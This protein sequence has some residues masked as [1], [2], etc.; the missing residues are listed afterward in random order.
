MGLLGSRRRSALAPLFGNRGL[1]AIVLAGGLSS[2]GDWLYMTALPVLLFL[3]SGDLGLLGLVAAIRL[4]PFLLLSMPAGALADRVPPAR[5]LVVSESVRG[6]AMATAAIVVVLDAPL[7]WLV[8]MAA[9]SSIAGTVSMPAQ[10]TLLPELARDDEELALAN[11]ADATIEG[12]ASIAG[13]AVAGVL[14]VVGGVAL[15][16]ALNAATFAVVVFAVF[17]YGLRS[18]A[19]SGDDLVRSA[20]AASVASA[21]PPRPLPTRT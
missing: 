18:H 8:A 12:I 4:V 21:V 19:T 1:L 10:G 3:R 13:P 9:I 5:V 15:A 2:V 7:A 16:F 6:L 14:L 20:S 17:R 11:S